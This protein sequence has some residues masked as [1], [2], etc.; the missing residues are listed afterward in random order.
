MRTYWENP[1]L[2]AM[3]GCLGVSGIIYMTKDVEAGEIPSMLAVPGAREGRGSEWQ[4][5]CGDETSWN[6]MIV[7]VAQQCEHPK[8]HQIVH[9]KMVNG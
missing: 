7:K 1:L 9:F 6:Q 2:S 5:V 8:C 4:R 3:A